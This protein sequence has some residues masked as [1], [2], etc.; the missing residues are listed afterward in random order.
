MEDNPYKIA[1]T[2]LITQLDIANYNQEIL[3]EEIERYHK[4]P[5]SALKI[6][7]KSIDYSI[8]KKLGLIDADKSRATKHRSGN[9]NI[10]LE[11]EGEDLLK[12]VKEHDNCYANSAIASNKL[13][14]KIAIRLYLFF[15]HSLWVIL[16]TLLSK[17]K[18][19]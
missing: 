6:F 10:S 1:A 17:R 3:S 19:R 7:I 4:N 9:A 13:L 5:K 12:A 15:K 14:N 11:L 16:K 2:R 18:K 8:N